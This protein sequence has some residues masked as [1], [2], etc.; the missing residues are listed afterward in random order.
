M[1]RHEFKRDELER[2]LDNVKGKTL[3][4]VDVKKVFVKTEYF[5]K[6]TGI[7]GDVIEQ[8]V[9]GLSADSE[10]KPDIVVDDVDTE[11]KTTGLKRARKG[12]FPLDAKEPMSITA[13]SP[14]R[15]VLEEFYDSA[16]WHKLENMLI[17]Y[18]LYDSDTTV[19]AAEYARFPIQDYHFHVFSE[20][21]RTV[22]QNDW[23]IV[24]DFIRMVNKEVEDPTSRYPEISKLRESMMFMDT[25][26]KYPNAPRFRLKRSVVGAIAQK[27]LGRDFELLQGDSRFST[28]EGLFKI[29]RS[30]TSE[31]RGKSVK[32]IA[33]CLGLELKRNS[34]GVVNKSIA[35]NVLTA[36]FGAE[37]GRL[38]DIDI[39]A[40]TG[41]IPKTITMSSRGLRTE[42]TKLDAVDFVEWA[43]ESIEF[44]D[45]SVY[46]YF[47]N[48]SLLFS[49]FQEPH[50]GS[51]IE[52]KVFLGFKR[53]NFNDDFIYQHVKKTWSRVRE[54]VNRN[55]LVVSEK[56]NKHGYPRINRAGTTVEEVN[57]PKAKD[58][59]VFLRG[60]GSDS[61]SK[62]YTLNG[63]TMYPQQFWIKGTVL[64]Q[65]LSEVD[66]I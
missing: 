52:D 14:D 63:L 35:E 37:S 28:Y 33:I 1:A 7:A 47:M 43:D 54:L 66:Y 30:F 34:K 27:Y 3:G 11:L 48:H 60:T 64:I 45:S 22:I 41:I 21:D 20:E 17:V 15:I 57:F 29:L 18:Y 58:N 2:I 59:V 53:V 65:M 42:D 16:L 61:A 38:R 32:D 46:N 8:S 26:P 25:A 4:E 39:F 9:L 62:T 56:R 31:Y 51:A 13:V 44:E 36:A 5:S 40:K 24:R 55:E 49:I 19:P 10:Q 23:E 50:A 12:E 6:V